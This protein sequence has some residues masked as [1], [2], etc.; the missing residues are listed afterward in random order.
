L[1]DRRAGFQPVIDLLRSGGGVGIL[2]DQHAG[3][4]GIWTPFFGKLASTSPLPALLAKRS[5]AGVIAAAVYTTGTARWRMVFTE[6]FDIAG[7]S[8]EALTSKINEIIEQQIRHAPEDGFWVHNRWKTP[9]PNFLLSRYKR[10]VYLPKDLPA[11]K[12]KPFRILIRSSNWLG[13]A[14]MSVPAVRAI[15]HG[16][17]DA[18]VTVLVP[19]KTAPVWK[20][21]PE[22]DNVLSLPGKSLLA[23]MS[24]IKKQPSFDAAILFPNSLRSALEVWSVPRKVG[25]RGHARGWLL[26]QIVR[27]LRR[28]RPP[29]HH[30]FR[31]LRIADDCGADVNFSGKIELIP[32]S[33]AS[34]KQTSVG[35]CPGAEYGPAKRWLPE[36]FAEVAESVSNGSNTKWVLF[37]TKNDASVGETIAS[38]L[39]DKCVNR[40]GQTTLDELISELRGCRALLTNDTGTMHLA[41]LLG[42]PVVAIFGSTEPQLTGPIGDNHI[43]IRHHVECSP[44]FLRECPIDFRCMKEVTTEEVARAMMSILK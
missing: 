41:A 27:E 23:A 14:V 36:R 24:L 40:I 44:C 19:E 29:E 10:G 16:R 1:F 18:H 8:I 13:D 31:F 11:E 43:V 3:D 26:N 6:R 20:L 30:A 32:Q 5:R 7:A 21:I 22:V 35:L 17:P 28:P 39:G 42:V 15:K 12:L 4:Q 25:Y 37:G 33:P 34:N 38:K 9:R 2:S